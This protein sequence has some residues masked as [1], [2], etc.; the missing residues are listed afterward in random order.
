MMKV[1]SNMIVSQVVN[2]KYPADVGYSSRHLN[3]WEVFFS[4]L[5]LVV[6]LQVY[7]VKN[8]VTVIAVAD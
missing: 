3:K 2:C 4:S 6:C 8:Y 5:K 1:Q 7:S